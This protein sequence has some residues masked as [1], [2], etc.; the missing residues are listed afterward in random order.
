MNDTYDNLLTTLAH[1]QLDSIPVCI[2]NTRA[3]LGLAGGKKMI[4]YYQSLDVK[5]S[6]QLAPLDL[7]E[8]VLIIPGYWPDYG[9][10][11]EGS[12]FGCPIHFANNNPPQPLTRFKDISKINSLKNWS[13]L[14]NGLM[15]VALM[16]YQNML[17][18]LDEKYLKRL[19]YLNGC[20]LITGPLEVASMLIG[21][22][23]FYMGFYENPQLIHALLNIVTE[24][25]LK[26]LNKITQICGSIKMLTIIE[27]MPGQI[28]QEHFKE[29]ALPY[30]KSIYSNYQGAIKV[31]HNEDNLMHILPLLPELN[32]DIFHFGEMDLEKTK[33]VIGDKVTL[34]GNVHPLRTL[35]KGTEEDVLD[36]A[37]H[38]IEYLA[39]EGGFILSSGGGLAP[40]TPL[41]NL[42]AM[43]A[44]KAI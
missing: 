22:T 7:W 21:H 5:I 23:H 19:P 20:A 33:N 10:A 27:H 34:M 11:L 41:K 31:Y 1:K 40:G 30:L 37:R 24:G 18:R 13:P 4:D 25:L 14:E 36:S 26:W 43:V 44:A 29:F 39:S 17:E 3:P 6:S 28:S 42:K 12:A 16:E 8:D 15:P 2:W 32:F 35:L 38:C 9:I